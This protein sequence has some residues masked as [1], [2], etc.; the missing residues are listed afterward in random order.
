MCPSDQQISQT[1]QNFSIFPPRKSI[2]DGHRALLSLALP[3]ILLAGCKSS[4]PEPGARTAL[5]VDDGRLSAELHGGLQVSLDWYGELIECE[6]MPRPNGEG[7]RL[8][9]AGPTQDGSAKRSLAFILAMPDLK[10]GE[11]GKELPT[12]VTMIEEI[13]GRF[14]ATQDTDTCWTDV[15]QHEQLG[16]PDDTQYRVSGILYCLA[17]LAEL[18]G[19][20]SVI[21]DEMEF[22][23]R[24]DWKV[25][26]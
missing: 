21:F 1:L 10:K 13:T 12:N 24:L 16:N 5:C 3:L 17:P 14:F 9:F 25:P 8:R 20:A 6:G 11:T 19:N 2:G 15:E 22:T 23:G 4:V 26:K 7:A 18:N